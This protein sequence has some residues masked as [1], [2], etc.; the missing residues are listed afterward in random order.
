M[1][2]G[3]KTKIPRILHQTINLYLLKELYIRLFFILVKDVVSWQS[4]NKN[5][6]FFPPQFEYM[7]LV[8][9]IIK[10]VWLLKL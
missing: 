9:A 7:T 5:L 6:L 10:V 3:P 1:Q 8:K 2:T 4:R